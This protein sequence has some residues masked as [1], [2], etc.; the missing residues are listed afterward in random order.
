MKKAL[1]FLMAMVILVSLVVTVLAAEGVFTPSITAKPAPEVTVTSGTAGNSVVNTPVIEVVDEQNTQVQ[2]FEVL[3]VEITPVSEK[4]EKHV[5]EEVRTALT[6]A[7]KVLSAPNVKLSVVMPELE[8]VVA[9]A[10]KEDVALKNVKVNE[11]VVKDLFNVSVSEELAKVL[12]VD[13]HSLKLTFDAK[14]AKNQFAVVMVY[15]DGKW[16][17]VDFVVNEDG[18]IT[19]T[20]EVVGV[21]A[22]LVKP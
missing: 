3:H 16:V 7:Y 10:A 21:V 11:L 6:E 8:N 18:T 17:P 1:S 12:S 22:V 9:E 4:D 14:I 19:C 13:A 15:T 2:T 20:M 5:D